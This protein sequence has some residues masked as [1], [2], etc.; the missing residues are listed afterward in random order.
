MQVLF[1]EMQNKT[2]IKPGHGFTC[3]IYRYGKLF[4]IVSARKRKEEFY[5]YTRALLPHLSK[6]CHSRKTLFTMGTFYAGT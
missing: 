4:E 5:G 6:E 1:C 3:K 2:Y